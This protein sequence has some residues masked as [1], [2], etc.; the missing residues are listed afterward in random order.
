[1]PLLASPI[2][3]AASPRS[4]QRKP[5]F[6]AGFDEGES[7]VSMCQFSANKCK[8]SSKREKPMKEVVPR[9]PSLPSPIGRV[10]S[11]GSDQ[12]EPRFR[13]WFDEGES[14]VSMCQFSANKCKFSSK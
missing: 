12:Y 9:C 2:G 1:M 10:A 14:E 3:R 4:D 7:E 5:R 13:A 8:F 6:R 11:P